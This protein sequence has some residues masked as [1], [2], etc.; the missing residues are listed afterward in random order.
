MPQQTRP[1]AIFR[2]R[3]GVLPNSLALAYVLL[4]QATG[5]ALLVQGNLW[6]FVPVVLLVAHSL[7]VAGY[8]IHDLAHMLVFRKRRHNVFL[9]EI[10]SWITG[11]AY[12]PFSRIARMHMRHH[13]DRADIALFDPRVFL[14]NRGRAFRSTIFALEWLHIPAVEMIMHYQIVLRPFLQEDYRAT[15]KRVLLVGITRLVFFATLFLANRWALLGYALAYLMFVKALFLADACAH[16]YE[17]YVVSHLNEAV[18]RNGRDAAYDRTHTFS[19]LIS[20]RW[21]WLNLLN[22]NFGYHNAHHDRPATP[23]HRLPEVHDSL[24]AHNSPQVLPYRELWRSLHVNRLKCILADY[25]GDVGTGPGRA[26]SFLGV[27]GVSFLS[28]V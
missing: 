5:L 6:L 17:A 12:A 25:T 16:T 7:I 3:D 9:G 23:W 4:G 2:H 10:L 26:D 24:Y 13:S 28:I 20:T 11:A 27:H 15:R 19:N 14:K 18:P 22:L 21:P 1:M 8:L